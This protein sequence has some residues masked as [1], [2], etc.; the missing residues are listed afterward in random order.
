M[1]YSARA[2]TDRLPITRKWVGFPVPCAGTSVSWTARGGR[3]CGSSSRQGLVADQDRAV[4]AAKP[5]SAVAYGLATD[6]S[7]SRDLD[8]AAAFEPGGAIV[9]FAAKT[10]VTAE[11]IR[12]R[13]AAP[14]DTGAVTITL[15]YSRVS[16]ARTAFGLVSK[17]AFP[18]RRLDRANRPVTHCSGEF[19]WPRV[20]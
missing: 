3:R 1:K 7:E 14:L 11:E 4:S 5:I 17:S 6:R 12:T 20:N 8:G 18:T 15:R 2:L 13:S 9:S 16:P 10:V 19:A